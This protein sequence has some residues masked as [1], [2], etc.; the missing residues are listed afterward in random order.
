MDN[1]LYFGSLDLVTRI[2]RA[3]SVWY[4]AQGAAGTAKFAPV[5]VEPA[6]DLQPPGTSLEL[7]YRAA[8]SI[9]PA[10]L[11]DATG[12]ATKIDHYG[13][14]YADASLN[15]DVPNP[16]ISF[17]GGMDWRSDLSELDGAAYYQVRAT[18]VA[19]PESG[20]VPNLSG[21]GFS[22]EE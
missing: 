1:T 6:A 3:Y 20:L 8:S 21:L 18:F 7:A 2:S 16:G 12:D 17:L 19:N 10:V 4:E 15:R 13:D 11:A 22:W 5:I 9:T 14:M